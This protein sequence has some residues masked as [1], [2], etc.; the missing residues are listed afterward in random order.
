MLNLQGGSMK[1]LLI[2]ITAFTL[3]TSAYS[4]GQQGTDSQM[5][6]NAIQGTDLPPDQGN[7]TFSG[8]DR[9]A[10][11][12]KLPRRTSDEG[13]DMNHDDDQYEDTDEDLDSEY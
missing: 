2:A 5:Q 7:G 6:T 11:D 13:N 10:Q 9:Q 4:Q 8:D 1:T 12:E 3:T